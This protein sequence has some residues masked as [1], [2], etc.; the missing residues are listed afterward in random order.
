V[1]IAL[2]NF[3]NNSFDVGIA[4]SSVANICLSRK[5]FLD[6]EKEARISLKILRA[7]VSPDHQY[8]ASAEYLL[9]TSLIG[10]HRAKEA[11]PQLRENMA[12]WTRAEAPPWRAARTESV[13]GIALLQLK[14][15]QAAKQAL[16]HADEVL[17]TKDSGAL[18]DE[19]E[20]AKKRLE[21]FQ[22]C[23]KE[24]RLNTCKVEL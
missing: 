1:V 5:K 20:S 14:E 21:Q 16:I 3:G 12:R 11:E 15:R 7:A 24:N 22:Q 13:L 2:A 9:A 18:P 8:I 19:I 6:T 4:H 23:E 10:Q 17:S